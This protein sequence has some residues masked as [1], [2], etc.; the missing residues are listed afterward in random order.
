MAYYTKVDL[1]KVDDLLQSKLSRKRNKIE[2]K[3]IVKGLVIYDSF[4]RIVKFFAFLVNSEQKPILPIYGR[5]DS[6]VQAKS[7]VSMLKFSSETETLVTI[8]GIIKLPGRISPY[9]TTS[10]GRKYIL[11]CEAVKLENWETILW[12]DL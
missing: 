6:S 3:G 1:M 2:V 4:L 10:N 8:R 7:E 9:I 11:E 5:T 12:S